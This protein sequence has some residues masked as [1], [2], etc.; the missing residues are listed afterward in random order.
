MSAP[1]T[2]PCGPNFRS[3]NLP[4]RDELS[5]ITVLALPKASRIGFCW[6]ILV[7]TG[8]LART[9]S[10]SAASPP[11]APLALTS[12][13]C[14]TN[15]FADSVLPAP[16][17]PEMTHTCTGAIT[18]SEGRPLQRTHLT[19]S[20]CAM[21]GYVRTTTQHSRTLTNTRVGMDCCDVTRVDIR[22]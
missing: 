16:D 8:C 1:V 3:I 17:S 9:C 5:F 12:M 10:A 14:L 7:S 2:V 18:Q 4:N 20:T 11:S 6:M 19:T 21:S 13:I 22:R 15:C